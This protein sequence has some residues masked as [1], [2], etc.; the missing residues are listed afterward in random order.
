M[1]YDRNT[2]SYPEQPTLSGEGCTWR[3]L[4]MQR[5]VLVQYQM[6]ERG[7]SLLGN[8]PILTPRLRLE[9]V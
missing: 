7:G 2:E 9:Q 5:L 3:T 1:E 4:Y 8:P 6:S